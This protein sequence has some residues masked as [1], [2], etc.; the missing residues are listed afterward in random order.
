MESA[1]FNSKVVGLQALGASILP[2]GVFS[3]Y[4]LLSRWPSRW[5]TTSS[6][7]AGGAVSMLVGIALIA[8]LPVSREVRI[9]L[10]LFYVPILGVLLFFYGLEFVGLAFG[11]WI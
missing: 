6:D 3:T 2:F 11:D 4:L 7:Y 10:L 5:F 1:K 8:T 9:L